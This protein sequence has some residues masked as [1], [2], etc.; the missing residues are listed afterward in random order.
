MGK[1]KARQLINILGRLKLYRMDGRLSL[2]SQVYVCVC[3]FMYLPFFA[4]FKVSTPPPPF[5]ASL[6]AHSIFIHLL[7][8]DA[9]VAAARETLSPLWAMADAFSEPK[10]LP[11]PPPSVWS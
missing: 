8:A 11:P 7:A 1:R 10:K 9:A 3:T 6:S 2:S 4:P 5:V